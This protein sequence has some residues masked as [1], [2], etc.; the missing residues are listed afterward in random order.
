MNFLKKLRVPSPSMYFL[1]LS[2]GVLKKAKAE[3]KVWAQVDDIVA[4]VS[5]DEGNC[6]CCINLTAAACPMHL[7]RCNQRAASIK[8]IVV[9]CVVILVVISPADVVAAIAVVAIKV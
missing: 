2:G 6:E 8:K 1:F 7:H 4:A 9:V 3:R 5:A